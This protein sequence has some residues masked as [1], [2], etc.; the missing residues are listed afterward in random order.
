[1][2]AEFPFT[3]ECRLIRHDKLGL[4]TIFIGEIVG[5]Q[6]REDVLGPAGIPDI[7]KTQAIV[8]GGLGSNHYF[9]IGEKLAPAFSAGSVFGGPIRK[10]RGR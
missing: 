5:I 7:E 10:P 2:S 8:W 6:A 9:A 1:M 4:H 3:L